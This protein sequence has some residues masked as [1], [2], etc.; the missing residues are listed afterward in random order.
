MQCEKKAH[1]NFINCCFFLTC[2]RKLKKKKKTIHSCS[3]ARTFIAYWCR[4]GLAF[5][6]VI[7][8]VTAVSVRVTYLFRFP[9]KDSLLFHV[10]WLQLLKLK[11]PFATLWK[12]HPLESEK[13]IT[14]YFVFVRVTLKRFPPLL[15]ATTDYCWDKDFSFSCDCQ[16]LADTGNELTAMQFNRWPVAL[17]CWFLFL[18]EPSVL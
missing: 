14:V 3:E 9:F 15:L 12:A 8:T 10:N 17:V 5:P 2:T 4:H 6:H 18:S 11:L 7:I 1:V 16:Q 13:C